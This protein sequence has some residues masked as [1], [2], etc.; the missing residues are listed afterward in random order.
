MYEKNKQIRI[1][2]YQYYRILY[3]KEKREYLMEINIITL[4]KIF[5]VIEK[6]NK[7]G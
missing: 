4:M 1:V 2:L 3:Q 5:S 6:I 7:F